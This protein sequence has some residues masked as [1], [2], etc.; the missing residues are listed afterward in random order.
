LQGLGTVAAEGQTL[1]KALEKNAKA[2]RNMTQ[3]I[4]RGTGLESLLERLRGAGKGAEDPG[5]ETEDASG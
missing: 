1:A 2:I 5:D 4:E 3:A